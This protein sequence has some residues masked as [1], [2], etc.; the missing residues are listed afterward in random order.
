MPA[1]T[2]IPLKGLVLLVVL[3][4]VWGTNWVSV[5]VALH[6]IPPWTL[7][8]F[9]LLLAG[10]VLLAIA[11]SRGLS[12][13]VPPGVRLRLGAASLT[14]IVIWNMTTAY[15]VLYLPSGHAAVIAFSMPLWA[16]LIGWVVLREPVI[17]RQVVAIL[18]GM[19]GLVLLMAEDL[20]NMGSAPLGLALV[21]TAAVS[22][23]IGTLVQKHTAWGM[24]LLSVTVWQLFL[25]ALPILA[26][27]LVTEA[28]TLTMPGPVA[29]A[30]AIFIGLVPLAGGML[31]WFTIVSI[32]PANVAALCTVLV[33]PVAVM[34]GALFLGENLGWLQYA[35]LAATVAALS[36]VLIQPA[37]RGEPVSRSAA[38]A[39][40][41][42]AGPASRRP[43]D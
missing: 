16:A 36:L 26:V 3:T 21:L 10:G 7:R 1:E 34:S 6:D 39:G 14:N 18:L 42:P 8:A 23:A 4:L 35:A 29:I 28:G 12:L 31:S 19:V 41:D 2:K 20:R 30:L 37:P 15:S 43:A 17:W 5:R 11:R 25:G 24:P 40:A 27:A 32:L 38:A 13:A 9:C 33:P 22:W